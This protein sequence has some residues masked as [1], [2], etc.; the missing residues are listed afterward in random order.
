MRVQSF[1]KLLLP[2]LT[3][4]SLAH[5]QQTGIDMPDRLPPC[6]AEYLTDSLL[7]GDGSIWVTSEGKGVLR[8]DPSKEKQQGEDSWFDVSYYEGLP[9]TVNYY[10]I[11]EDKQG[12][13]WVG[14]DNRGAAVFNGETWKTY[15]RENALLG[16]RIFDIAV[17]PVTGDVAI[18]TSGGVNIYQ[19]QAGN[20][21]N[22]TRA[23][24]LVEDQVE[25]LAY[26]NKGNLWLGYQCGGVSRLSEKNNYQIVKTD[27]AKWYWDE[28]NR[29]RQPMDGAGSGLPSN[30]CNAVY[31]ARNGTILLGTNSGL[32]LKIGS[33]DWKYVRGKDYR[34][35]NKG[36]WDVKVDKAVESKTGP[37]LLPEDYITCLA[38]T[39]EGWWIGFRQKGAVLLNPGTL[40]ITRPGK[41]PGN[42]KNPYV[43]SLLP[44]PN[45][46]VYAATY[47]HGI[48]NI[49]EGRGRNRAKISERKEHPAHPA[50][51]VV[52]TL[53]ELEGEVQKMKGEKQ[54]G[55]PGKE[56]PVA[57]FWKEDWSTQGNWCERYGKVFT[58]LFGGRG[59]T[60][61]WFM[62]EVDFGE[63]GRMGGHKKET[64]RL[65]VRGHMPNANDN[66]NVLYNLGAASRV[67]AE[68]TDNGEEYDPCHDGPDMWIGVDS[69][70][71]GGIFEIALYF[72]NYDGHSLNLGAMRDYVVEL[73]HYQSELP[74]PLRYELKSID[75]Y[76]G[77][78]EEGCLEK[79]TMKI[80]Q[81]PVLARTRVK[82]FAGSG[83]Y[84]SFIIDKPGNYYFRIANNYSTDV[85]SNGIFV[86]KLETYGG[87]PCKIEERSSEY[88]EEIHPQPTYI[89]DIDEARHEDAIKVAER[90]LSPDFSRESLSYSNR[91]LIDCFRMAKAGKYGASLVKN[92]QWYLRLW[93][94]EDQEDFE[95]VMLR[96]WY[97]S[98]DRDSRLRSAD[99][100]P[101]S[102]RTIPFDWKECEVME[103]MGIDWKTYLP[104]SPVAPKLSE[105]ELKDK[106]SKMSDEEIKRIKENKNK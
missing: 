20:W 88:S 89:E 13:I 17:S 100:L 97:A 39:D 57:V 38:E 43:M 52:K 98:Q 14:S 37:V 77:K 91:V 53:D 80:L 10:A 65:S 2:S 74:I 42:V 76:G 9:D 18:A 79:E 24:G 78:Y 19:P 59:N 102:P 30:L 81:S 72:Y 41:F 62:T 99:S 73:R 8:L 68:L 93:N 40:K 95:N 82:S 26:D 70:P 27:Q 4:L 16:E 101:Y 84:K 25:T 58:S 33:N 36:L 21:L 61:D 3:F 34:A 60:N 48:V 64:Q 94:K 35:K 55:A 96:S 92:W 46:S 106:I 22:L 49:H 67:A 104:D 87:I 86:T 29:V 50:V 15:N 66:P 103:D 6:P 11:A 56:S 1:L 44:L 69:L 5:G 7:A 85:I 31:P 32:A 12:C 23:E 51:A 47:G 54:S 90:V 83:V 63:E 28:N 45:G 105:Q 75:E 71:P